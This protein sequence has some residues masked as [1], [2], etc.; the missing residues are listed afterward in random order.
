[1]N[2]ANVTDWRIPVNGVMRDVIRVK[3]TNNTRI[4]WEK[5]YGPDDLK[6]LADTYDPSYPSSAKNIVIKN[7]SGS[8]ITITLTSRA[9]TKFNDDPTYTYGL[10][11]YDNS[12]AS[13]QIT[14][15]VNNLS[16]DIPIG[17]N[18]VISTNFVDMGGDY[19]GY[20]P[21]TTLSSTGYIALLGGSTTTDKRI[22][23]QFNNSSKIVDA[24]RFTWTV[25]NTYSVT[26]PTVNGN[27]IN[28]FANSSHLVYPAKLD[29]DSCVDWSYLYW[30]TY[31]N[32][33]NL[34]SVETLRVPSHARNNSMCRQTYANCIRLTNADNGLVFQAALS[35]GQAYTNNYA[36]TSCTYS[37]TS[38]GLGVITQ[39]LDRTCYETFS[40]CTGITSAKFSL[41]WAINY[42]DS[43]IFT[44]YSYYGMFNGCTSLVEPPKLERYYC[45]SGDNGNVHYNRG[46]ATGAYNRIFRNCTSLNKLI[47]VTSGSTR[48]ECPDYEYKYQS[49]SW[50]A[51][52][53]KSNLAEWMNPANS[54]TIYWYGSYQPRTVGTPS[55][56]YLPN[57]TFSN[58]EWF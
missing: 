2:F 18:E 26:T 47:L 25:I 58:N 8:P 20:T 48:W 28:L 24:S 57:W 37:G 10:T 55:D 4:I 35:R 23:F 36:S 49:G 19:L 32:C 43:S 39:I 6:H 31:Y 29:W 13:H 45:A 9:T 50:V 44:Q 7:I 16:I 5:T 40:G 54:G 46:F 17:T 1:M 12:G 21:P 52:Q 34:R 42:K 15:T 38:S 11:Y 33:S 41:P 30:R 56:G 51:S 3:D 14:F 22:P 27:F 53:T